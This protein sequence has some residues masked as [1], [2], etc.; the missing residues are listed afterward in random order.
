MIFRPSS[1]SAGGA[2]SGAAGSTGGASTSG[3]GGGGGGFGAGGASIEARIRE[4]G[5]RTVVFFLTSPSSAFLALGRLSINETLS[6]FRRGEAGTAGAG[7]GFAALTGAFAGGAACERGAGLASG[8]FFFGATFGLAAC[9][10][11]AD[12]VLRAAD[13]AAVLLVVLVAI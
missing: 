2:A 8:S 13:F 1:A 3:S 12:V 5:G 7:A 10:L 6:T 11:G 4:I 9:D